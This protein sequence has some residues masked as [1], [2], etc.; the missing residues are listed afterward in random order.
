MFP[1][2]YNSCPLGTDSKSLHNMQC[3]SLL[4][5]LNFNSQHLSF[6]VSTALQSHVY[7][8]GCPDT[9][10]IRK[11]GPIMFIFS[12]TVGSW[13]IGGF[14]VGSDTTRSPS[15]DGLTTI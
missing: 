7:S 5:L 13:V 1:F 4:T 11:D 10:R 15:L 6:N 2:K 12:K 14:Q 3:T 9:L 8:M